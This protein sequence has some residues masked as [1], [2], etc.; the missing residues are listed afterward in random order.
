MNCAFEHDSFFMLN[1]VVCYSGRT[2]IAFEVSEVCALKTLPENGKGIE[3]LLGLPSVNNISG[4]QF[5]ELKG[6]EL[7]F[8]VD[9]PIDLISITMDA[10][11]PLPPLLAARCKLNGLRAL[12]MVPENNTATIILLFDY[13]Q[14]VRQASA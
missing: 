10:I 13:S 6:A 5:I 7:P 2:R 1:V 3:A 11:Y 12:A 14:A 9:G 8:A 4:R